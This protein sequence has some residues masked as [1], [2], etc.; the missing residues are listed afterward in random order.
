MSDRDLDRG[1]PPEHHDQNH[2]GRDDRVAR[3]YD[4]LNELDRWLVDRMRTG[5]ADPALARFETWDAL[6]SRLVDARAGSLANRVRRLSGVVGASSDWHERV[7]DEIGQLHLLSQAG[8]RLG[9]LPDPL[10]DR[11][12]TTI[13]WQVRQQDVLAGVPDTDD[14]IVCG[15][16]DTREDRI[17]VRRFWLR[18][19]TSNR[20]ALVLSFAAYRQSL[21][22]SIA[23]GSS[24][25]ADLHRYPGEALR[26][27]IGDRYGEP[28]AC[29][30]PEPRSVAGACDEIGSMLA[31]E[32]WLDRV[33]AVVRASPTRSSGRWALTDDTGTLLLRDAIDD[34]REVPG[35]D[36]LLAVS[37]G[38]PVDLTVE[39]T[40]SGIV[41]L[42]I[43]R[44]THSID[45]GP[46]A[47]PSFVG[48]A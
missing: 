40:P 14:W 32:P 46:R 19:A 24:F 27:L 11:V 9:T 37:A 44:P 20:W 5:L 2:D 13:G 7:L 47:E 31:L 3:M 43:H 23:V 15:R 6:A 39:W 48:A 33:P 42:T 38:G 45:I 16:S 1:Q 29:A 18:G 30:S 28:E 4:G 8:R 35:L 21:D 36:V 22:T 26:A 17:E 10:A 12:A 25:R 41:P 34:G